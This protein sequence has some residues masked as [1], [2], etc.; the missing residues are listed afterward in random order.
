MHAD[1]EIV[2]LDHTATY[3]LISHWQKY[4]PMYKIWQ[5]WAKRWS[6]HRY[7]NIL[8]II[9]TYLVCHTTTGQLSQSPLPPRPIILPHHHANSDHHLHLLSLSWSQLLPLRLVLPHHHANILIIIF[10]CCHCYGCAKLVCHTTAPDI[11]PIY[12]IFFYIA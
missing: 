2:Y 7:A 12:K 3:T 8:T 4:L 11:G 9:I 10:I 5:L 1:K 6:A